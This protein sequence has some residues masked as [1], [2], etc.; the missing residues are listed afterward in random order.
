M[1]NPHL[2]TWLVHINEKAHKGIIL[3]NCF[4]VQF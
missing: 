4:Y 3:Y 2:L 1:N